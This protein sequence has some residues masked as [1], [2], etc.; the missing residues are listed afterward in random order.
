[1]IAVN[2]SNPNSLNHATSAGPVRPSP[3][4]T[5][6]QESHHGIEAARQIGETMSEPVDSTSSSVAPRIET[7][8]LISNVSNFARKNTSR[9]MWLMGFATST[10]SILGYFL[11]G[12]KLLG[13]IFGV[14]AL[15]SFYIAHD[16]GKKIS[17]D[18][19]N[20]GRDPIEQIK[21]FI[22]DPRKIEKESIKILQSIEE[23]KDYFVTKPERK[24][25]VED[26]LNRLRDIVLAKYNQVKD[27]FDPYSSSMKL[28]LERLRDAM[29]GVPTKSPP[30][31]ELETVVQERQHKSKLKTT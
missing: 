5:E 11:I 17:G 9:A 18:P 27:F 12:S 3:S 26:L 19:A 31:P 20:I 15:M 6:L 24:E 28:E 23:A 16:V 21:N 8:P 13:L 4:T 22:N 30:N 2:P 7:L 10:L 25:E 29:V 14:P 1:M